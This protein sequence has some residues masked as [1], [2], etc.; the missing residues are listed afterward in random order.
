MT[1]DASDMNFHSFQ[2]I[3]LLRPDYGCQFE[4]LVSLLYHSICT[5]GDFVIDGG[6]NAGLHA[7]PLANLVGVN[8]HV[9]CF[10]PIPHIALGLVSNLKESALL[11]RCSI[12]A[13]ALS[14]RSGVIQFIIDEEQPALSH[15]KHEFDKVDTTYDVQCCTIDESVDNTRIRFIKLDLEGADFL[16]L[17]G[18]YKTIR[19]NMPPIIFE[20]SRSWASDCYS[21]T[22]DDFFRFFDKLNYVVVDLHG[23]Y[24]E[25]SGW[26]SDEYGF[27]FMA[28][29]RDDIRKNR[30]ISI[31]D[32]FWSTVKDRPLM[33]EW[34]DC[35]RACKAP[36]AYLQTHRISMP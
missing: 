26:E 16:A 4:I 15:I 12:H 2:N 14:D 22:Q 24:L 36:Y 20:N 23:K 6:A 5:S 21:Y 28:I 32:L 1:R 8:G 33:L 19:Q 27:E 29:H 18:A 34:P 25:R 9:Y 31:I 3:K 35:V 11:G 10:E 7:L 30:L 13:Q 17:R